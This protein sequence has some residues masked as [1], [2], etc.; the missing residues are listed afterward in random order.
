MTNPP[1]IASI[2]LI[3]D[4]HF[5]ERLF[6]LPDRLGEIWSGVGLI[7][8][9]G[10]VGDPQVLDRLGG[11]A[12]VVAVHGNDDPEDTRRMLPG[13]CLIS[14]HGHRILLWH[15]H[16]PDPEEE[17]ARRADPWGGKLERIACHGRDAGAD[18]VVYGHTHVP[19][20]YRYEDILL[21][22]PGALASGS[23]FTRQ[24]VPSVGKLHF[25]E[26]GRISMIHFYTKTGRPREFPKA[27]PADAFTKLG[28]VYQEWLVDPE[29][30]PEIEGL[31]KTTYKDFRSVI[32][33]VVPVYRRILDG[34]MLRRQD[35]IAAFRRAEGIDPDDRQEVLA[36]LTGE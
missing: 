5:Q 1:S 33:A 14:L 18:I 3:S 10:D 11:I 30:L 24:A 4:T 6:D 12:P 32:R 15:G 29:L 17:Q 8:H 35:L 36:L 9:A 2:G 19:M 31:R 20:T 22:N 23:Y 34:G 13:W 16:F 7:L 26:D 25:K 28:N 21:I 27:D